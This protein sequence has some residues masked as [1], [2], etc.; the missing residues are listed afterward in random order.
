MSGAS[1][2]QAVLSWETLVELISP[3]GLWPVPGRSKR[4]CVQSFPLR[5]GSAVWVAAIAVWRAVGV[6]LAVDE[7]RF[8]INAATPVTIRSVASTLTVIP[9]DLP[10]CL[11]AGG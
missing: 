4:Y 6:W 2:V 3:S 10:K 11:A 1:Q 8:V 5:A 7:G 9:C